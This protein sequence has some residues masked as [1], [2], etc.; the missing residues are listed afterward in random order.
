[1]TL[2]GSA[3]NT[4][5]DAAWHTCVSIATAS[6]WNDFTG[7]LIITWNLTQKPTR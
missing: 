7:N 2:S 1:M 4:L 5:T 6:A 3:T